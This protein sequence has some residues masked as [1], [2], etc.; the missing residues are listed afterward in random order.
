MTYLQ[1]KYRVS[2]VIASIH[3][4]NHALEITWV[5]ENVLAAVILKLSQVTYQA[6]SC[7][8]QVVHSMVE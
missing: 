2:T 1:G 4:G 5:Q 6:F 7:K 3:H 8:M